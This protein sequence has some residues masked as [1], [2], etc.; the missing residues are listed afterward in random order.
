MST[1]LDITDFGKSSANMKSKFIEGLR[2]RFEMNRTDDA[3]PSPLN[4]GIIGYCADVFANATEDNFFNVSSRAKE[5]FVSSAKF[6]DSMYLQASSCKMTDFFAKPARIDLLLAIPTSEIFSSVV[7]RENLGYSMITLSGK[8]QFI[9]DRY[10]YLIDYPVDIIVKKSTNGENIISCKYQIP[11]VR[12][13]FS[14]IES[15][16]IP[17]QIQTINNVD[18]YV[19]KVT[20]H[21]LGLTEHEFTYTT[22]SNSTDILE[23]EYESQLAGFRVWHRES[24]DD[25]WELLENK[26]NGVLVTS[27]NTKFCYFRLLNNR[28]NL[29]FSND[30][31]DWKP[32]LNDKFK[33]QIFQ[34]EG[35]NG[36]FD[37]NSDDIIPYLF[38]DSTNTYENAFSGITPITQLL[39]TSSSG[40]IDMPTIEDLRLRIIDFKASRD[41]II[42][43]DDFSRKTAQY[44]LTLGKMQD[45]LLTRKFVAYS[46]VQNSETGFILPGRT[47]EIYAP[48]S[49]TINQPEVDSRMLNPSSVY[50]FWL[51]DDAEYENNM[52]FICKQ[53]EEIRSNVSVKT[54]YF[55]MSTSNSYNIELNENTTEKANIITF[56]NQT[57]YFGSNPTLGENEDEPTIIPEVVGTDSLVVFD[58]DECVI[59]YFKDCEVID[60]SIYVRS[61][62][63]TVQLNYKF[64]NT[65]VIGSSNILVD[66]EYKMT[67]TATGWVFEDLGIVNNSTNPDP[68]DGLIPS[69]SSVKIPSGNKTGSTYIF[70]NHT[71]NS[72]SL[73]YTDYSVTPNVAKT[74]TLNSNYLVKFYWNGTSWDITDLDR[75]GSTST[76]T[77][78]LENSDWNSLYNYYTKYNGI[79][80]MCPYL[81]KVFKHPYFVSMYDVRSNTTLNTIF[82]YNNYNSPEKFAVSGIT[83]VRDDIRENKYTI[84]CEIAVSDSVYDA[85]T[86]GDINEFPVKVKIELFNKDN[87]SDCYFELETVETTDTENRLKFSTVLITDNIIHQDDMI[88]IVNR[89]HSLIDG[90]ANVIPTND[91]VYAGTGIIPN[92]WF[93][94]FKCTARIHI[95]YSPDVSFDNK[96]ADYIRNADDIATGFVV[97]DTFETK[98]LITFVNDVSDVFSTTLE[99]IK[100]EGVLP[101][102]PADIPMKYE[103]TIYQT[104]ESG[105][106]VSDGNGGYVILHKV[107]DYVLDGSG[108]RVYSHHAGDPLIQKDANGNIIYDV[109]PE[110]VFIIKNVPLVSMMTMLDSTNK[111]LTYQ[112][113]KNT[114]TVVQ[115]KILP[116][117]IE[118]NKVVVS[119]YNTMG[120]SKEFIEGSK[121]NFT[122]LDNLSVS[123]ALN[124]KFND[125]IEDVDELKASIKTS[126]KEYMDGIVDKGYFYALDLSEYI[127]NKYSDIEYVEFSNINGKETS[128]QTIKK[129]SDVSNTI[130]TPEY[131]T[132]AQTLDE[133]KFKMDGTV[134][135]SPNIVINTIL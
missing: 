76:P 97:T 12:N 127:K 120:P 26:Y 17:G 7:T 110:T 4:A 92:T 27:K 129:S 30:P 68:N 113:L 20:A 82:R 41:T 106:P 62:T 73:N 5:I 40:G 60:R 14:D 18:Y 128:V 87:I 50:Q 51:A 67:S 79:L 102:Y 90:S 3:E 23:Y 29:S 71:S 69:V 37:Y 16:Y 58:G 34:T 53:P 59:A 109:E 132:V 119:I 56:N 1:K 101:K 48:Q 84:S 8:T 44:G 123:I 112:S 19:F 15:T 32:S 131:I 118:N 42:S 61:L 2:E 65:G 55:D 52:R 85:F 121:N 93:I 43:D 80:M 104:D 133:D 39:T 115:E 99:V 64:S 130:H 28:I 124:I 13:Q 134:E 74:Y 122:Q 33:I 125:S 116:A 135:L 100:S 89:N 57:I 96:Y 77:T 72:V 38:Q 117:L 107:G 111:E 78:A 105:N 46:L 108:N 91:D 11:S 63:Q 94:P 35:N 45:D 81:I 36:N 22:A 31:K 95:L 75:E 47:G 103:T 21:Q 66:H 24:N 6:D 54:N 86:T 98:D 25:E 83:I 88:R 10:Y 9:L 126:V 49:S 70:K 114:T